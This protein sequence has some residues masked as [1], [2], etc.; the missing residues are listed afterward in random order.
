M[1]LLV[2]IIVGLFGMVG[3]W[4]KRLGRKQ[5]K[6]SLIAYIK[7]NPW[8]TIGAVCSMLFGIFTLNGVELS[9]QLLVSAFLMGYTADSAVNK[10]DEKV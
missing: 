6:T 2:L 5:S 3:H 8:H 9:Q 4:A 10:D 7:V 1:T